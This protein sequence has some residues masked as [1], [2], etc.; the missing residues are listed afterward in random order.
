VPPDAF[1]RQ[2]AWLAESC[3]PIPLTDLIDRAQ[4]EPRSVA[5]TFDDGYLDNLTIASRILTD[6]HVP[7]TFFVTTERLDDGAY[8]Y[9]WDR[10]ARMML[11]PR[12][13]SRDL[14]IETIDGRWSSAMDSAAARLDAYRIVHA[15]A[16]RSAA[17]VRDCM[18][19]TVA[20]WAGAHDASPDDRRLAAAELRELAARPDHAIGVH[21]ER[22]L[23]LPVQS[24]AVQVVEIEQ[25][26]QALERLLGHR[27]KTIAYPFGA[28]SAD[29]M[30]VAERLGF[31]LGVTMEDRAVTD[32]IDPL[33]IPRLEVTP[34]RSPRFDDWLESVFDAA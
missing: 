18:L 22:H 30:D 26:A 14:V 4:H 31:R 19:D 16:V 8:E 10:L 9:W 24:A 29:V 25:S 21:T 3:V 5:V 33:R 32:P 34:S 7:A 17:D 1:R 13:V 2:M 6:R 12:A 11:R 27:P 20:A 28:A 23:F 15:A